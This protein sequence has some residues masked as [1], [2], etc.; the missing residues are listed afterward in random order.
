[1]TVAYRTFTGTVAQWGSER[2]YGYVKSNDGRRAF[3]HVYDFRDGASVIDIRNGMKI[4]F[5]LEDRPKG[6]R[7][8]D[9]RRI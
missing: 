3:F 2:G 4:E 9:L 1:M 7:A 5:C 8:R 6:L